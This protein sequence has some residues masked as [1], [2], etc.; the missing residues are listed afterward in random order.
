MRHQTH[1]ILRVAVACGLCLQGCGGGA[2]EERFIV[3]ST[4]IDGDGSGVSKLAKISVDGV[5]VAVRPDNAISIDRSAR[6]LEPQEYRF[7]AAYADNYLLALDAQDPFVIEILFS[8]Q[9]HEASFDPMAIE[10]QTDKGGKSRP[11]KVY[12]LAPRYSTTQSLNPAI[13]LCRRPDTPSA[14][15]GFSTLSRYERKSPGPIH[16]ARGTL[17]CF[18]IAFG[19]PRVDPRA[20]FVLAPMDIDV[21]GSRISVPEISFLSSVYTLY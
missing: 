17:Y 10:L 14:H 13:P 6:K 18:A 15:P 5:T 19:I 2:L 1:L 11:I 9:N 21:D 8:T 3:S 20:S 4:R 7:S 12:G 16:L